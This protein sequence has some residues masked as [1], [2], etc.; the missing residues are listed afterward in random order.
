[1]LKSFRL[2]LFIALTLVIFGFGVFS[3]GSK[4][5]LLHSTYRL[6]AEFQKVAGLADGAVVQI[7]GIHEGTVMRIDLP[8]GPIK[9]SASSFTSM[10]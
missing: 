6:Q 9:R 4:R 1:M 5:F 2:E 7:G 3:I 10:R 8:L